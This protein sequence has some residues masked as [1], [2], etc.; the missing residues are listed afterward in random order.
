MKI[1]GVGW[2]KT[3]TTTLGD[4]FGILGYSH[5]GHDL[6]LVGNLAQAL[7]VARLYDTFQDWPW[8]LY[9]KELDEHFPESKFVLTTR[10][11]DSWLRS[12]RNTISKQT[13]SEMLNEARKKIYGFV[14]TEAADEQLI[15]R[16]ERHNAEVKRHFADR[17]RDLLVVNWENGD[18]WEELCGFL[19]KPVPNKPFPHANRGV[20]AL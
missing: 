9:Y 11:C 8:I 15:E 6:N 18:G 16:Y 2:A 20:Y 12:Y 10:D 4:C 19:G 1:F 13:P 7:V 5:K 3:G 14:T 17:P